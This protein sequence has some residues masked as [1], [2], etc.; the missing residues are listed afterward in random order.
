MRAPVQ[1]RLARLVRWRRGP[2]EAGL[3]EVRLE[4]VVEGL[5]LLVAREMI[6]DF[7]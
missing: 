5:V 2:G 1:D 7:L 3:V 4:A 6:V